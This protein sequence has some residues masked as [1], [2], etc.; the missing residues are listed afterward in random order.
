M[1]TFLDTGV[2]VAFV[3]KRDRDHDRAVEL[4]DE[5]RRGRYGIPYTS[6]YVFDEAVTVA[7]A[8]TRRMSAALN[9]G[10]L[11]LGSKEYGTSA[12]ARMLRVDEE[13]FYEAWKAF[14]AH[15][16]LELSFTD[17]TCISLARA[18]AGGLI[19]SFDEGFDGLLTR[20]H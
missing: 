18:Y 15:K 13:T 19:M 3:N 20:I 10:A 6:D 7:L 9:V 16:K 14:R 4:V 12:L 2:F 1:S 8:R 17:H 11:I 5:L